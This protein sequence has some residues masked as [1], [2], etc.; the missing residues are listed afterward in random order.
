MRP[1]KIRK[2]IN[3]EI[4]TTK[5]E[6]KLKDLTEEFARHKASVDDTMINSVSV[7]EYKLLKVSFDEDLLP[8]IEMLHNSQNEDTRCFIENNRKANN[9]LVNMGIVNFSFMKD[10]YKEL[11]AN[12]SETDLTN[13]LED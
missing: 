10:V 8:M 1:I 7:E 11:S 4:D 2:D 12:D 6:K 5:F 9:N 3:I 13:K